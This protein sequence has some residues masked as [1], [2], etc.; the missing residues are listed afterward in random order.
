[1][2]WQR[3]VTILVSWIVVG[4][5]P[6][7]CKGLY[8]GANHEHVT[9]P[10]FLSYAP[11][12]QVSF[13]VVFQS[14][15]ESA[16]TVAD[17]AWQAALQIEP[18]AGCQ[19]MLVFQFTAPPV[20]SMFGPTPGP[21]SDLTVPC[22]HLLVSDSDATTFTGVALSAFASRN[23]LQMTHSGSADALGRFE[24]ITL[25]FSPSMPDVGNWVV[26]SGWA[27]KHSRILASSRVF[28][29]VFLEII[30]IT[31]P[32]ISDY[33][34][35]KFVNDRDYTQW[36]MDYGL[37]AFPAGGGADGN[38]NRIVDGVDYM[39]WPKHQ[40]ATARTTQG[41]PESQRRS[42]LLSVVVLLPWRRP[43]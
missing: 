43:S 6:L 31:T 12:G 23:T 16:T 37:S 42:R 20:D 4:I 36:R 10:F 38:Q 22:N 32:L 11:N 27:R 2:T 24:L 19:R 7:V 3:Q 39:V 41:V 21:L 29:Y 40:A 15:I 33:T 28:G 17:L 5:S 25:L 1:M 18:L 9:A 13:E 35:D 34:G 26:R 14:Y 8:L 30:E